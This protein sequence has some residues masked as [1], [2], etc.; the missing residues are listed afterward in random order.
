MA[1][2]VASTARDEFSKS[3]EIS[4]LLVSVVASFMRL[5]SLAMPLYIFGVWFRVYF[6]YGFF[7]LK[8]KRR[9]TNK[10]ILNTWR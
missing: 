5:V 3:S 2:S 6:Y 9:Q 8:T 1:A 4:V 10:I 7:L